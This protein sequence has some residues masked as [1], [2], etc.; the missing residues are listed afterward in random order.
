MAVSDFL[1]L[2]RSDKTCMPVGI[3]HGGRG[4]EG[5]I[6]YEEKR[7]DERTSAINIQIRERAW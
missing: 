7:M 4:G 2:A 5:E 1:Y 3:G 6:P